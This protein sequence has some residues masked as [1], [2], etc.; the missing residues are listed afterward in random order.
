MPQSGQRSFFRIRR[1]G[2]HKIVAAGHIVLGRKV[3]DN[4]RSRVGKLSFPVRSL[5]QPGSA[6]Q[7]IDVPAF[8]QQLKMQIRPRGP[9]G[10]PDQSQSAGRVHLLPLRHENSVQMRVAGGH[11]VTVIHVNRLSVPTLV[12]DKAYPSRRCR[13]N[14]RT[15]LGP[16]I[17][18]FVKSRFGFLAQ[19][20]IAVLRNHRPVGRAHHGQQAIVALFFARC[21]KRSA[22][23]HISPGRAGHFLRFGF[24]GGAAGDD[25][26]KAYDDQEMA[27]FKSHQS[28]LLVGIAEE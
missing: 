3:L 12:A 28:F 21:L 2:G 19:T 6:K 23:G 15:P 16:N 26:N 17:Y 1:I 24:L 14:G 4:E 7:G 11:A 9:A 25:E 27:R 5:V 10:T 22:L 18:T 20:A 13:H 8:I